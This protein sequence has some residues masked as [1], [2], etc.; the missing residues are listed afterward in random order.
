MFWAV[1]PK[2]PIKNKGD[3]VEILFVT[4]KIDRDNLLCC[5]TYFLVI[6]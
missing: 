5:G 2:V 3:V 4:L 1:V 6:V